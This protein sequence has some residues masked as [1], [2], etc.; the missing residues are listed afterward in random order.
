M[1][2]LFNIYARCTFFWWHSIGFRT[3][4]SMPEKTPN[5][6]R[7]VSFM[8]SRE[9][10]LK[11]ETS[12]KGRRKQLKNVHVNDVPSGSY[13]YGF[14][15]C[16]H[17]F[18]FLLL[19]WMFSCSFVSLSE[20]PV[21]SIRCV[22]DRSSWWIFLVVYTRSKCCLFFVYT[23]GRL[24]DLND[25]KCRTWRRC[26]FLNTKSWAFNRIWCTS[27]ATNLSFEGGESICA[28]RLKTGNPKMIKKERESFSYSV[29]WA[30]VYFGGGVD[31]HT[32]AHRRKS[33]EWERPRVMCACLVVHH[34]GNK[35]SASNITVHWERGLE[36]YVSNWLPISRPISQVWQHNKLLKN[37]L[38]SRE[39]FP[40]KWRHSTFH[41]QW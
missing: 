15:L 30:K 17:V 24:H 20:G 31:P 23:I 35:R 33:V 7:I 38:T 40:S 25:W 39:T 14:F 28:A 3:L 27:S 11:E 32:R 21:R 34:H 4:V 13:M 18:S 26:F 29:H 9:T 22:Y 10:L 1:A 41:P 2:T 16:V 8:T 6:I 19:S 12:K 5:W 36:N 37:D